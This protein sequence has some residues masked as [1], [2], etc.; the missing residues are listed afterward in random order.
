M[1]KI[2]IKRKSSQL[3]CSEEGGGLHPTSNYTNER[4]N[5][6]PRRGA[7]ENIFLKFE[8]YTVRAKRGRKFCT[9]LKVKRCK[10]V[11]LTYF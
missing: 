3:L 2:C 4:V 5:G 8:K 1:E 6:V 9:I 10:I 11:I 7:T